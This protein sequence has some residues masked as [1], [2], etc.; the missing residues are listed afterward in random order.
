[1][2]E[3]TL[4]IIK[5]NVTE[6]NKIGEVIAAIEAKGFRIIEMKMEKWNQVRAAGFYEVHKGKPFYGALVEF[7]T[8]GAVVPIVLEAENCV[9][10]LRNTIGATDPAKAEEGTVRKRFGDSLTRNAVHASDSRENAAREI[11]Y[12]F[13]G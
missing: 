13:G 1:M 3:R 11:S 4:F 6:K 9:E 2:T 8:S 5:P 10:A 7:M 12:V